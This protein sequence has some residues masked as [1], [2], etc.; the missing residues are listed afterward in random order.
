MRALKWNTICGV[1]LS[2]PVQNFW[3]PLLHKQ[4]SRL[5][6]ANRVQLNKTTFYVTAHSY[7]IKHVQA[8]YTSALMLASKWIYVTRAGRRLFRRNNCCGG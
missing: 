5:P 4:A 3:R 2:R 1:P 7:A 6:L 8:R